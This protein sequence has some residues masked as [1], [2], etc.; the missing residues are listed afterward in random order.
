MSKLPEGIRSGTRFSKDDN[1]SSLA[2]GSF[3]FSSSG[4]IFVSSTCYTS[5]LL[6]S[7][8]GGSSARSSLKLYSLEIL[9]SSLSILYGYCSVGITDYTFEFS[10]EEY[11]SS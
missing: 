7:S 1:G 8:S 4:D 9:S 6:G 3:S 11:G 2:L 5:R 10:A